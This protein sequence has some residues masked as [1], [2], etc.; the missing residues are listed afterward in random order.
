MF[1]GD[2]KRDFDKFNPLENMKASVVGRES[3]SMRKK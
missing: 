2:L 3:I 1:G